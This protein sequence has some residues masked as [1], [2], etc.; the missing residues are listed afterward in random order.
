[1]AEICL[2]MTTSHVAFITQSPELGDATQVAGFRAGYGR[3]AQALA[4]ARPE[5]ALLISGEHVNKFFLDNMPAF[6]IGLMDEFSG[7]VEKTSG[8]PF[9]AIPSCR[10]LAEHLLRL[11]LDEGVDWAVTQNWVVDHGMAVP[12]HLIDP[13]GRVPVVPI[14]VNCSAPPLPSARRCY[15]VGQWLAS[16][17][18]RWDGARR[19]AI[20]ATGGLSHSV[21]TDKMGW[22]DADFDRRFLES[23]CAGRAAG[24]ADLT[25]GEM[26]AAGNSTG[27]IRSWIVLAGAMAGRSAELVF[28]E[29]ISGFATG[30]AQCLIA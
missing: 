17:V 16:A 11:G 9:R 27:E 15:A 19:V 20:I 25:D 12:L 14:H 1:M 2:G 8:V 24:V 26:E 13:Q 30:C 23:F 5:A 18:R 29:P 22:I 6:C 10:P 3:L 4:D 21:G 28:Y 7:P